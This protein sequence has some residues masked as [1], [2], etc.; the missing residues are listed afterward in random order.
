VS[1]HI[2]YIPVLSEL[3]GDGLEHELP[4]YQGVK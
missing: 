3:P 2:L 1:E 4:A